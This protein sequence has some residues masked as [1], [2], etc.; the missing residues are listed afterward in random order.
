MAIQPLWV[1][2][3]RKH[4]GWLLL[5]AWYMDEILK[6]CIWLKIRCII[7]ITYGYKSGKDVLYNIKDT[8]YKVEYCKLVNYIL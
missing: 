4:D 7:W 3:C 8:E 6:N 5:Y 2:F 1:I